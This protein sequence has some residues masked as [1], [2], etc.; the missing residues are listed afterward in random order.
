MG[1]RSDAVPFVLCRLAAGVVAVQLLALT[2][3][4]PAKYRVPFTFVGEPLTPTLGPNGTVPA[5]VP[6]LF[7]N[8]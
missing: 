7:H 6:S 5:A 3:S 1:I 8:P 4:L 2:P